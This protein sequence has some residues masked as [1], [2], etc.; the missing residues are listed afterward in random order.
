MLS[1]RLPKDLETRLDFLAAQTNRTKS[2]YAIEALTRH[3]EEL[4]DI[5]LSEKAYKEFLLSGEEALSAD[6][7]RKTLGL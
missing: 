5:Y 7:A 6:E 4:E 1:V 3:I 2:F